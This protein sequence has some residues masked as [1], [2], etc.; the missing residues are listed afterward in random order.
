M[1]CKKG[2]VKMQ[3]TSRDYKILDFIN[4]APSSPEIIAKYV[5]ASMQVIQRRMT[6]LFD[7]GYVKRAR[8]DLNSP[9]I[10][11]K[12]HKPKYVNHVL[13]FSKLYV[14]FAEQGYKIYRTKREVVLDTNL[15]SDGLMVLDR[16]EG[17]EVIIVE[18]DIW[19]NPQQKIK[20]YEKFIASGEAYEK[21][22]V[23][24]K[25]LFITNKHIES[26][27]ISIEK[28]RLDFFE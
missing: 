15:R 19:T 26:E 7:N 6:V 21:F 3:M 22:G 12:G 1:N 18:V 11:Y 25:L 4:V 16:G 20:K 13:N 2:A 23:E 14:Y 24:P 10:Y 17:I 5:G 8:E 9:Y 27:E 28:L